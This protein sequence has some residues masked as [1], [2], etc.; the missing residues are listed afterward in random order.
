MGSTL[1]IGILLVGMSLALHHLFLDVA[2]HHLF[3]NMAP[4]SFMPFCYL[5]YTTALV[6]RQK[7]DALAMGFT[8]IHV[9]PFPHG[10]I[11]DSGVTGEARRARLDACVGVAND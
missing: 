4:C 10:L 6:L 1:C 2:P 3:L 11:V 8:H 9:L 7:V 5:T